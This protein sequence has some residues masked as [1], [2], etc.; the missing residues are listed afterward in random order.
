ML[1]SRRHFFFGSLALPA[2]AAKKPT[3]ERPNVLLIAVDNLP[4]WMLSCYGNKEVRT[5]N[6]QRLNDTGTRCMNHF[7][8]ACTPDLNRATLVSGRTPMQLGESG[9]PGAAEITLGKVLDDAG[10]TTHSIVGQPMSAAGPDALEFLDQQTASKSFG[11]ALCF[12]DLKVPYDGVPQ[13]YLDIYAG[14]RFDTYAADPVAANARAG[15]E[16]LLNRTGNLRKVAA[17]ITAIDDHI[18]ALL[19]K[20]SQKQ[21]LDNTLVIFVSTSGALYGRHGLWDAGT[22]SDPINMYDEVVNTPI[23]WSWP[24]RM[25][26]QGVVIEMTSAYDMLPTLCDLLS[27]TVP[28]RNLCGRSYL[29]V[30]E[31]K[32]LPKKLPWRKI[33]C[34]HTQNTDMAREERYKLVLRDGGKGSN[35][36]YDMTA[37][38]GEKANLYEV[39]EYLDVKTRLTG[40]ITRWKQNY[41][42]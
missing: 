40:E 13:K 36:L 31:R 27:I 30:A 39:P 24:H 6:I 35:E 17:T 37:D 22:A 1:V 10:Y 8:A 32:K 28:S 5:P 29:P 34:A 15:K 2:L 18:G 19:A 16:M 7:S 26:P 20:L 11:L 14:E 12:G 21:L 38:P 25:P 33:V 3:A 41:S 23:I 4:A 9:P 42:S